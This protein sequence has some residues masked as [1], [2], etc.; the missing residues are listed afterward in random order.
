MAMGADFFA[1]REYGNT[2]GV[3]FFF[4]AHQDASCYPGIFDQLA[5]KLDVADIKSLAYENAV[6]FMKTL[7]A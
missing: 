3:P 5:G 2:H 1:T 4:E 7:W 6:R